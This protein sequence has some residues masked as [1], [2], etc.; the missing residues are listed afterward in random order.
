[1][2]IISHL[3]CFSFNSGC[4]NMK[5]ESCFFP[6][7]QA[8]ECIMRV[9]ERANAPVIY[10]STDAAHS[11][12]NLLQSFLILNGRTVPLVR[13]PDHSYAEKWDALLYRNHIGGDIQVSCSFPWKSNC[14]WFLFFSFLSFYFLCVSSKDKNSF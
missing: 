11:E 13:R 5:K 14:V 1:M 6:I 9:I 3:T 4:S 12:T 8:A 10:L 2:N 7:P